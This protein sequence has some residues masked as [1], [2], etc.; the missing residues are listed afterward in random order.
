MR[1]RNAKPRRAYEAE[2]RELALATV[3]LMRREGIPLSKAARIQGVSPRTVLEFARPAL[4]LGRDGE[5]WA[6]PYDHIPRTL[7]FWTSGGT[8][9]VT[10]YDSR[11]ATDIAEYMNAVRKY[12]RTGDTSGLERFKNKSFVA[13]GR[14]RRFVT[15]PDVLDELADAGS[16]AGIES[17]Y[18]ARTAS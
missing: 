16:L 18:Y 17:L 12:V 4:R 8:I 7:N 1:R 13:D 9:T 6:L 15:D 10:V 14:V 5:Y 11:T 3:A 2:E